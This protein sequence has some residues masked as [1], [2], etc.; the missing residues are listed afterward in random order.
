MHRTGVEHVHALTALAV[1]EPVAEVAHVAERFALL[2]DK[3]FELLQKV[4]TVRAFDLAR[5]STTRRAGFGRR[6][7]RSWSSETA[8]PAMTIEKVGV[9]RPVVEQAGRPRRHR[10]GR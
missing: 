1:G 4:R 3:D 8:K 10:Q 5:T 2:F 7:R 9:L 6:R